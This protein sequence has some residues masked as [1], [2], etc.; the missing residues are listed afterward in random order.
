MVRKRIDRRDQ[1]ELEMFLGHR[2]SSE[3]TDL[4]APFDPEYLS[5]AR[6]AIEAIIDDLES[7]VPNAFH[8]SDT[9]ER[10]VVVSIGA[11]KS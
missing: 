1:P 4:Y 9:A 5:R 11:G 6:A 8:R 10:G 2:A 3:T 7:M